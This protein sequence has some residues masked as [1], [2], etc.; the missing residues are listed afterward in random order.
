MSLPESCKLTDTHLVF[1]ELVTDTQLGKTDALYEHCCFVACTNG[2][3]PAGPLEVAHGAI[4]ALE[5][6]T[7]ILWGNRELSAEAA[8]TYQGQGYLLCELRLPVVAMG[9]PVPKER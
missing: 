7:S 4:P 8:G 6:G 2:L 5:E 1:F 9:A 3:R